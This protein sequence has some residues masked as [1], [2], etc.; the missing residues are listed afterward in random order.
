MQ[1]MDTLT[2]STVSPDPDK[3]LPI[4]LA[5]GTI[6]WGA[7]SLEQIEQFDD[8][9]SIFEMKDG[10]TGVEVE[11]IG[12]SPEITEPFD[13]KSIRV[14]PKYLTIDAVIQRIK[15]GEI[16]LRPDFQR[17]D[18]WGVVAQSRLIE[19]ILI[20]IPLPAFYFDGSNDEKWDIIDGLQR[21][22]TLKKFILEGSLTLSGLEFLTRYNG[23]KYNDLPKS[24][25]RRIKETQITAFVIQEGVDPNVKFHIFKRINTGGLPLSSQEIRHALNQGKASVLL[26]EMAESDLFKNATA[27]GIS[28]TRMA[29]REC[30]LRFF[31]FSI[32]P[33]TK[34]QGD[35][36]KFLNN[37][38][39]KINNL[40]SNE[41]EL[42]R[43]KFFRAMKAA[44][45]IFG[46]DAFRKRYLL[47][48]A[49][50]PINKALFETWSLNLDK[51][52]DAE[53][54]TI[55]TMKESIKEHFINLMLDPKF[56]ASISQG[57]GSVA[58][59]KERFKS[60]ENLI[61]DVL[62]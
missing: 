8:N 41:I 15:F 6:S 26:M 36:H 9:M 53:L 49:R 34:Y 55:I 5:D 12:P 10:G 31:A 7:H 32:T 50:F 61:T 40:S 3:Y 38:M 30:V 21:L 29:D 62:S 44:I 25:H 47:R 42:L 20:N 48:A 58:R 17:K 18:I 60:I 56:D 4:R 39:A 22:L 13:P 11:D 35:F 14:T 59:V 57:T 2:F 27:H 19:S 45:D 51:L 24:F 33:Y 54:E 1:H 43:M 23:K 28:D 52:N 16:D 37:Q 46:S